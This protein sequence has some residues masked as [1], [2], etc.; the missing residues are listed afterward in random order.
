MTLTAFLLTGA[1]VVLVSRT[2]WLF[3][4]TARTSPSSDIFAEKLLNALLFDRYGVETLVF[5]ALWPILLS[6]LAFAGLL[7]ALCPLL[8]LLLHRPVYWLLRKVLKK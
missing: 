2:L 8:V 3:W 7:C 4:Q 5:A 1:V 6:V